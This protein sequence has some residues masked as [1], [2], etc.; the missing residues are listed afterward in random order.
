MVVGAER[1]C[2]LF[3]KGEGAGRRQ[4]AATTRRCA[5]HVSM[6]YWCCTH[7]L[8]NPGL[9]DIIMPCYCGAPSSLS[10]VRWLGGDL[11]GPW[12]GGGGGQLLQGRACC[13]RELSHA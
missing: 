7:A 10:G 4:A 8:G 5:M 9:Q 12:R 11:A 6:I 3:L 1:G 13:S 2:R